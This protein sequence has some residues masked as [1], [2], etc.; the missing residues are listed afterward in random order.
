MGSLLQFR[1]SAAHGG[2]GGGVL[3]P[4]RRF[5]RRSRRSSS[6]PPPPPPD[7]RGGRGRGGDG[8]GGGSRGEDSGNFALGLTL[9]GITTL[10]LV[11][12]AVSVLLRRPAPDWPFSGPKAAV[13]ALWVSTFLLLASSGTVEL[14]ARRSRRAGVG[15]RLGSLRWLSASLVLGLAFLGA[16]AILWWTL[17]NA[18]LVPSSSGYAAVFFALTGLH[19][20]HVLGGLCFFAALALE[21]GRASPFRARRPSV[22]LGAVYWHFMGAI[23]L[24]LF[25]L[26]YFVR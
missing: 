24:V 21:L 25:T 15:A 17:W 5:E 8:D 3:A 4:P 7:D 18:G 19:A 23:W 11:L 12:I 6:A 22:R 9:A 20:L 2:A 26:L 13:N 1:G 14:A 16:Q 10:F